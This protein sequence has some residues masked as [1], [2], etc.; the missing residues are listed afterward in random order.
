MVLAVGHFSGRAS[1]DLAIADG[2]G[3]VNIIRGSSRGLTA[4]GDQLWSARSLRRGDQK[5]FDSE[6]ATS[7]TVGSFGRDSGKRRFDD[8]ALGGAAEMG[9]EEDSA[10][11]G[12]AFVLYGSSI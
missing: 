8:L 7:M 5:F 9:D 2:R 11:A 3:E 1:A 12:S 4:A 10:D 6:F